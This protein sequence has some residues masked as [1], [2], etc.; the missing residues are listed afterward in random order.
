MPCSRIAL[1][2]SVSGCPERSDT[3]ADVI[4][5]LTFCAIMLLLSLEALLPPSAYPGAFAQTVR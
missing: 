4:S 3:G 1:A 2:A 5:S